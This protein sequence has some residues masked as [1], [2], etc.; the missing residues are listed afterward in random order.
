MSG[1]SWDFF[2]ATTHS[3]SGPDMFLL[4]CY[5]VPANRTQ[6][7]K[8]CLHRFLERGQDSV[9][10]GTVPA[11]TWLSIKKELMAIFVEGDNVWAFVSDNPH[12]VQELFMRED[13]RGATTFQKIEEFD[14]RSGVL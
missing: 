9:F 3:P 2:P 10:W 8:K 11:S 5:D 1:L 4:I 6:V 12:N 7:Y 13:G 14:K